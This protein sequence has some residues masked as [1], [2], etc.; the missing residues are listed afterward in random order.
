MMCPH[1]RPAGSYCPHCHGTPINACPNCGAPASSLTYS[2][3]AIG[4]NG[5]IFP[6]RVTCSQCASKPVDSLTAEERRRVD[7]ARLTFAGNPL[8]PVAEL[9]A[10]IDRL[11]PHKETP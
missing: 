11:A 7:A 1:A 6:A 3:G 10:I 9:L 4:M 5:A 8:G 2:P